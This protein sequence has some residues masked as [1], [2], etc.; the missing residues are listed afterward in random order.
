MASSLLSSVGGIIS[1]IAILVIVPVVAF[2]L[3]LDWDHL[4]DRVDTLLPREHAPTL[5]RLSR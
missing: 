3:L 1:A 4:V 2:Y 5:R